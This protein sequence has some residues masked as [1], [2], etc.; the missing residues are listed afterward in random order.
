M[1]EPG[2]DAELHHGALRG[3]GRINFWSGSA[4]TVWP[5]LHELARKSPGR[6]VRVLDVAT[7]AGDVPIRLW[8][9]A[10]AAGVGLDISGCDVSP[11]AVRFAQRQAEVRKA[12]V[13]F[14][15][16]NA[17]V[18]S[19]PSGYDA[20]ISSLFLHHLDEEQAVGF[21]RGMAAAAR[22][23]VLVNDLVRGRAGYLLAWLGTRIFSRSHVVH[24]DGPRSVAAAFTPA[25]ARQ[26]AERAGLPAARV[27]SHWP[28]RFLLRWDAA[29]S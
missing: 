13:H 1:D 26:L 29:S 18:D 23:C 24:V 21:L 5:A 17:L 12:D 15:T 14:F 27:T 9:R 22:R 11:T 3:L 2:L 20:V 8:H 4:G 16:W 25:E 6:P 28:C 10:R 7:G 19:L